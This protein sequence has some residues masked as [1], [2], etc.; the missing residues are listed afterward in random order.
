MPRRPNADRSATPATTGGITRGKTTTARTN[1]LPR[2]DPRASAHASGKPVTNAIAA[3]QVATTNESRRAARAVSP[4]RTSAI[5]LHGVRTIR[6]SRGRP[7]RSTPAVAR[8]TNAPGTLRLG[9]GEEPV[10]GEGLL[11]LSEDVVDEA[12]REVGLPGPGHDRDR[13]RRDHVDVVGDLDHLDLV[14]DVR[15]DVRHVDDPG[16][17]VSRYHLRDDGLHVLL[18]GDDVRERGLRDARADET[19][20]RVVADGNALRRQDELH[21]VLREVLDALDPRGVAGRDDDREPV[22][23]EVRPALDPRAV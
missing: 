14:L 5:R 8:T 18:V 19:L 10:V 6:P 7:T 12:L 1:V 21:V 17:G 15:G 23:G 4:L 16:V 2:N 3:A 9:G 13:I 11:S 22:L 20:P